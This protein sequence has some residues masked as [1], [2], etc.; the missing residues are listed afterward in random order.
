MIEAAL[1]IALVRNGG[2]T[3]WRKLPACDPDSASWRLTPLNL[4]KV[5]SVWGASLMVV[6]IALGTA[7]QINCDQ[8]RIDAEEQNTMERPQD[9]PGT[10]AFFDQWGDW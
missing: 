6:L 8:T 5:L 7:S 9:A 10:E 3:K 2:L 4:P 1:M